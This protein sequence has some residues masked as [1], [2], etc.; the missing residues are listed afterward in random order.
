MMKQAS[1]SKYD[2]TWDNEKKA[3]VMEV[4]GFFKPEDGES[5]IKDYNSMI[6]KVNPS[7]YTLVVDPED[8]KTSSQDMIPVLK[9]CFEL[10]KSSGFKEVLMVT[11]TSAISTMQLKNIQKETGV[12]M[13]FVKSNPYK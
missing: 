12:K 3:I 4:R 11:P 13:E 10:Y 7:E 5:F 9:G 1:H 2:I 6:A 8:L